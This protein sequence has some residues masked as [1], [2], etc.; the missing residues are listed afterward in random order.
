MRRFVA[1]TVA[2]V[3]VSMAAFAGL[4][5]ADGDDFKVTLSSRVWSKYVVGAGITLHKKPAL[6]TDLFVLSPWGFYV[7]IWQS[8]GMDGTSPNS[9]FGDEIDYT[10]GWRGKSG[11]TGLNFGVSYFDV[12]KLFGAPKEDVVQ[13]YGEVNHT[14]PIGN[15]VVAPFVR[16]EYSMRPPGSTARTQ[17]SVLVSS[18]AAHFA[19]LLNKVSIFNKAWLAYDSGRLTGQEIFL[20]QSL[21]GLRWSPTKRITVEAPNIK[22]S[23]PITHTPDSRKFEAIF[24]AGVVVNLF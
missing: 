4:A 7:D 1:L 22:L 19:P 10:L 24:G 6:Q 9:D 3:V 2:A 11:N 12:Y 23:I 8:A 5:R 13:L 21:H 14:F 16:L 20:F 15:H 18:G 17:A